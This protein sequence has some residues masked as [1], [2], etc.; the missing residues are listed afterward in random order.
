MLLVA[1]PAMAA[2]TVTTAPMTYVS[3]PTS[4]AA[5]SSQTPLFKFALTQDAGETLSSVKVLV[6]STTTTSS[7]LA[8]V[9][10]YKDDG[11]GDFDSAD[12]LAG[13]STT[14]N[15]GSDT[16][17]TTAANNTITGGRFFVT[18]ATAS[19]WG[20]GDSVTVTM[21]AN[22]IT[23][24][25]NSPTTTAVTTAAIS[26][27][28]TA[29]TLSS[30]VASNTGG[31]SAKEAGDS[32]LLSFSEATNKPTIDATNIGTVLVL[33]NSHSW[34]DG[35]GAIGSVVWNADGK[36]LKI[37]ISAGTSLPTV[38]VGD[39]LTIAGTVIKDL[40]GNNATGTATITGRFDN[41]GTGSGEEGGEDE[42]GKLCGNGLRNGRLYKSGEGATV[43]LAAS[44][45]L[46]PFRGSAVFHARGHKFQDILP[47]PSTE[48]VEISSKPALPAGGTLVKGSKA[49][50]WFVTEGGK[51]K[52]FTSEKAFKRLGFDFRAVKLISDTDLTE[53]PQDTTNIDDTSA[54]PEGAVLKCRTA[55]TVYMM[56]GNKKV[57][58]TNPAPYLER[59]HTWDAIAV[60]DC[61]QFP[62][63]E[64]API[65]Q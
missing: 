44:C 36:Q 53:M 28:S 20:A 57:A 43:Y 23:T 25:A 12:L 49:T 42:H 56:K 19:T 16:I 59:G 33:N 35:A 40:A 32:I 34:L 6:A 27:D 51:I 4:A 38:A 21:P 13:T 41:S 10:V 22:A 48:G 64:G 62:Y 14:V 30:A 24:S 39:T 54:H 15:V 11:N 1:T 17:I 55:Q 45:R 31:T 5:S 2:V 7:D 58:F 60:I 50:V 26:F 46:K 37:T 3:A 52:G 9:S 29:P 18:F 65:A 8:S 63:Q 47:L 61:Q